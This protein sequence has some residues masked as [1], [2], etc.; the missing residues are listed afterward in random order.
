[1]TEAAKRETAREITTSPEPPGWEALTDRIQADGEQVEHTLAPDREPDTVRYP[2]PQAPH[3]RDAWQAV[4]PQ[5]NAEIQMARRT[6]AGLKQAAARTPFAEPSTLLMWGVG[7]VGLL[8]VIG[9]L[10]ALT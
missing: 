9:V 2:D 1:M 5:S 8:L 10:I 3:L 6:D 7:A 4:T